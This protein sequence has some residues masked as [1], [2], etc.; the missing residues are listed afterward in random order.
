MIGRPGPCI[1]A[2]GQRYLIVT[3]GRKNVTKAEQR[4]MIRGGG[5]M[6]TPNTRHCKRSLALC[7]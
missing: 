1:R 2:S 3:I 4:L 7:L 6:D 5:L